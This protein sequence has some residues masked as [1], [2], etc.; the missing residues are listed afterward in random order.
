MHNFQPHIWKS[1]NKF[2]FHS[3]IRTFAN[4]NPNEM[5]TYDKPLEENESM[6]ANEPLIMNVM[7]NRNDINRAITGDEL[8]NRLRPRI[9][10][11]FQ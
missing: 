3:F 11:L 9:K 8:L 7:N 4:H 5:K 6:M 1:S 10:S 2:G